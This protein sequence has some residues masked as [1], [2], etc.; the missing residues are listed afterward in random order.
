MAATVGT[1]N[2]GADHSVRSI[3]D[4][5]HRAFNGIV[6]RWPATIAFKF[7]IAFKEWRV[8]RAANV[9]AIFEM[10]IVFAGARKFGPLFAKNV[11]AFFAQFLSPFGFRFVY[12]I[13]I[14]ILHFPE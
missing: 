7:A 11:V 2:F 14:W 13:F 9:G 10:Q 8:A 6:K 5:F 1:K 3:A 12:W 4:I